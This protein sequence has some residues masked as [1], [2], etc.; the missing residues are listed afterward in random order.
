MYTS[1]QKLAA[2]FLAPSP[3]FSSE[4]AP[5]AQ[6]NSC[7]APAALDFSALRSRMD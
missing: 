6:I 1:T 7:T 2:E 5:S 3:W 4:Q